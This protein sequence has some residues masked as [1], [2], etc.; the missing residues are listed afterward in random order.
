MYLIGSIDNLTTE[1][2]Q[3]SEK[4]FPMFIS[5]VFQLLLMLLFNFYRFI[6][7]ACLRPFDFIWLRE[8]SSHGITADEKNAIS[9]YHKEL[10]D[11]FQ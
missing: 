3:I 10:N 9:K 11:T 2:S 8:K 1:F 6:A 7:F 5:R 4:I